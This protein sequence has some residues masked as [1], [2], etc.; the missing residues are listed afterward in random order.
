MKTTIPVL[1]LALLA[2]VLSAQVYLGAG[3][4]D[5]PR[6]GPE[7]PADRRRHGQL[8]PSSIRADSRRDREGSKVGRHDAERR[9]MEPRLEKTGYGRLRRP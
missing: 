8:L 7:R 3:P 4:A 1:G 9:G 6:D 5:R 2:S